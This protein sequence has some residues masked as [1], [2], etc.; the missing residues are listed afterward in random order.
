MNLFGT[1]GIRGRYGEFL[2]D[3]VAYS[4]GKAIA[5]ENDDCV[6]VVGSD[7]RESG[8]ALVAALSRG[9]SDNG[10]EVINMGV[11]PTNAVAHYVLKAGADYGVMVSASHN[12]PDYNGLKVFD[13]YGVKICEKKQEEFSEKISALRVDFNVDDSGGARIFKDG[14]DA[15][16]KYLVEKIDCDFNGLKIALDCCYGSAYEIAERV[17]VRL[18]GK[19]VAYCNFNKGKL[20]NVDCGATETSFL[21]RRM[22]ENDCALGFAFD[23]DAD[24]LAAFEGKTLLDTDR[25]FFAFAKYL[26]ESG[27]LAKNAVVGTILTNSGLEKSLKKIGIDLVRTDVGDSKIYAKMLSEGYVLGGENSGHYLLGQ[28]ATGSDALLNAMLLTKIYCLKGSILQY[29]AEYKPYF[30]LN[31]NV[32]VTDAVATALKKDDKLFSTIKNAF[33][34]RYP[35]LRLVARMS[36]TEPKIRLFVEGKSQKNVAVGMDYLVRSVQ[37]FVTNSDKLFDNEKK[38]S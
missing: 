25:V 20:I 31:E 18:G 36:G 12:P 11:V 19:I 15:Y 21:G 26:S 2:T 24:R 4:L 14:V 23:G 22:K 30:S 3:G 16:E 28:Y 8:G 17:F 33:Y 27:Q 29:T 34:S 5:L 9:V 38:S 6:V 37:A 13:R 35:T 32:V 10:G 7:T 1:D